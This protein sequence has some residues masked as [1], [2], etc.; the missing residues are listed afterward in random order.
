MSTKFQRTIITTKTKEQLIEEYRLFN[1]DGRW[2]DWTIDEAESSLKRLGFKDPKY[3][4]SGFWS[5]GDGGC[6]TV[7]G[8]HFMTTD[9]LKQLSFDDGL[10][11]ELRD[12]IVSLYEETIEKLKKEYHYDRDDFENDFKE[13]I[14]SESFRISR[15]GHYNSTQ[16]ITE[17]VVPEHL[18]DAF[19]DIV[20]FEPEYFN[21][22]IFDLIEDLGSKLYNSLDKEYHYL[23]SD[24]AVWETLEANEFFEYEE[25]QEDEV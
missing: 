8:M 6:F 2:Y 9:E 1:V 18:R 22:A 21:C 11:S 10:F 23:I 17:G 4:F 12:N 13:L 3:S 20:D 16:L 25:L 24:E 15:F 5:Q 19:G 14:M 7:D